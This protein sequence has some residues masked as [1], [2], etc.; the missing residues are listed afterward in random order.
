METL[1]ELVIREGYRYVFYVQAHH[2]P[3]PERPLINS[4]E[5]EFDLVRHEELVDARVH[6]FRVE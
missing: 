4:L 6:L 5:N 3:Y 2:E 1:A